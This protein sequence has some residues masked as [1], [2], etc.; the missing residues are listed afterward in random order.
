MPAPII[1]PKVGQSVESCILTEWYKKKGDE[2]KKG[3]LLFSFETDKASIDE[4]AKAD[5][6]LLETFFNE[7]DEV[8]V[9]ENIG[10]IGQPGDSVDEFRGAGAKDEILSDAEPKEQSAVKDSKQKAAPVNRDPSDEIKISPR[11]KKAADE[12]RI[13]YDSIP[14]SGPD[15]RILERDIESEDARLTYAAYDHAK[16][17]GMDAGKGTGIGNMVTLND[18]KSKGPSGDE[19]TAKKISNIRRLIS[20]AMHKSIQNSAQLTHHISAEVKGVQE[21]RASLKS[22]SGD[23]KNVTINDIICFAI[24]KAL[25]Q[26]PD[27]NSH[28]TGTE[29]REFNVVH[30]GIAVDTPR[31]LMVPA[32]KNAD[33]MSITELSKTIKKRAEECRN[34]GIDPDL[35]L[36]DAATFTISNLGMYGIE[37]FTP[38]LNIPQTGIIGINTITQRPVEADGAIS[39]VPYIGISLTYDHR[40][41]DGAPASRFLQTVKK[42]IESFSL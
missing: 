14:G 41:V 22:E 1:M 39:L 23:E 27:I 31:G 6:I 29:I 8:V 13:L 20:D 16:E 17:T 9:L 21:A 18:L 7:G 32:V 34:G 36:P 42:E 28:F 30:L 10:V 25:K 35:L 11:A 24:I 15:G 3:E 37:M 5:G 33:K 40:A 26:H 12:K 4:E 2:V 38:V 19:Y